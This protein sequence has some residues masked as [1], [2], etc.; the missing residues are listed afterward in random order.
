MG[1]AEIIEKLQKLPEEK[2]AEVLDFVEFLAAR[3][4]REPF[5]S[6]TT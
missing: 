3:L 5:S 1:Y 4:H 2:Q 6:S